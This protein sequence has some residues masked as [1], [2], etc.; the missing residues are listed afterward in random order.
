M[1]LPPYYRYPSPEVRA[2]CR[3]LVLLVSRA[4]GVPPSD[5]TSHTRETRAVVARDV[6]MRLMLAAGVRRV[7]LAVAFNRDLRRVRESEVRIRVV[8]IRFTAAAPQPSTQPA[9]SSPSTPVR[10]AQHL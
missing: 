4:F 5:I 6:A 7:D 8:P 2:L 10:G 1:D 9:S 3:E